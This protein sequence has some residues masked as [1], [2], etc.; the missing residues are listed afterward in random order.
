[1]K[2]FYFARPNIS[3]LQ[4]R[5]TSRSVVASFD[6]YKKSAFGYVNDNLEV[7]LLIIICTAFF[8]EDQ[9]DS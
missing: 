8:K 5:Q 4:L 6:F 7:H 9:N 1:M 2:S 3:L